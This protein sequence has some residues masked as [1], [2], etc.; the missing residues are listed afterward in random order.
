MACFIKSEQ[1]SGITS[2]KLIQLKVDDPK[3]HLSDS[4]IFLVKYIQK[5]LSSTQAQE[6][7]RKLKQ[8]YVK[9]AQC[10]QMKMPV[11][12]V[13]LKDGFKTQPPVDRR[14]RP[15]PPGFYCSKQ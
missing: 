13:L 2:K 12:N 5:K 10:L 3:I 4:A 6:V 1:L 15:V 8:A 7:V 11:N 14:F 9:C